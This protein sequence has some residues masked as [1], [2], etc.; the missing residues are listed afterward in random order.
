MKNILKKLMSNNES[1]MDKPKPQPWEVVRD[2]KKNYNK[3]QRKRILEILQRK[4]TEP[5]PYDKNSLRG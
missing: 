3:A 5:N 1:K 2:I 4:F